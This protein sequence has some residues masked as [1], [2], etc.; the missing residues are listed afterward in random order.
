MGKQ[1][2]TTKQVIAALVKTKGLVYL[3]AKDLGC[4]PATIHN[5]AKRYAAVRE[6]MVS[7]RGEI[8]DVAEA[9][10]YNAMHAGE[11]WAVLFTLRT[12]GKARGYVER[13]Q[14][15]VGTPEDWRDEARKAG[16][17]P[18]KLV[19]DLAKK[20]PQLKDMDEQT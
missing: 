15:E 2:Y 20:L 14:Q 1:R 7:A 18:D 5:Y 6:T 16:L 11:Q 13:V 19:R 17:D 8:V 12:Q 3:A 10:L 4:E 9:K